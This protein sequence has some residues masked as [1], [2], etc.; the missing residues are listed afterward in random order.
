MQEFH[1]IQ[2]VVIAKVGLRRDGI[3]ITAEALQQ[4]ASEFPEVLKYDEATGELSQ[5]FPD[6]LGVPT[7][8]MGSIE[9]Q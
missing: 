8:K 1:G 5:M 9:T 4:M 3:G 6:D 7:K 2:W